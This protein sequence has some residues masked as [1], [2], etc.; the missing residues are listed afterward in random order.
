M[1][2]QEKVWDCGL[3][4][5]WSTPKFSQGFRCWHSFFLSSLVWI[6]LFLPEIWWKNPTGVSKRNYNSRAEMRKWLL[7][8]IALCNKVMSQISNVFR[9]YWNASYV[10]TFWQTLA[11]SFRLMLQ[12]PEM[13]EIATLLMQWT[14]IWMDTGCQCLLFIWHGHNNILLFCCWMFAAGMSGWHCH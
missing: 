7:Q 2:S 8:N 14:V 1:Y 6:C 4:S 10:R 9:T 11:V 13:L 5:T 3:S 12:S